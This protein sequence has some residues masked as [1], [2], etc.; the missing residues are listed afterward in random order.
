METNK[1]DSMMHLESKIT[2]N[3][4]CW[5]IFAR[6]SKIQKLANDPLTRISDD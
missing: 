1:H 2:I 3:N 6:L 4:N 5:T